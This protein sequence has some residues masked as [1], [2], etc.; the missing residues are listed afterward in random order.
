MGIIRSSH[1]G[2][3]VR[4]GV[5]RNFAK[6]TGNTC[7]KRKSLPWGFSCEFCE[8]FKST[9]LQNTSGQLLLYV[10]LMEASISNTIPKISLHQ[11]VAGLSLMKFLKWEFC[12]TFFL[13][14]R[15]WQTFSKHL[16]IYSQQQ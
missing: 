9:F 10:L 4:K 11:G 16:P 6:F 7:V 3:S 12:L 5:L 13:I 14:L 2:C 8:I 15:Y 1:R